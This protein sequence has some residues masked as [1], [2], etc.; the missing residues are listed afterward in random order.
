M[1]RSPMSSTTSSTCLEGKGAILVGRD[2]LLLMRLVIGDC[3]AGVCTPH[4]EEL[5]V[6]GVWASLRSAE[7]GVLGSSKMFSDDDTASSNCKDGAECWH[8]SQTER[9]SRAE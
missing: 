3:E 8:C 6:V 1:F 7:Q 9:V 5:L 4:R 2:C